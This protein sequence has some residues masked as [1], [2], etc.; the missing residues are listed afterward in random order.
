MGALMDIYMF[1][2]RSRQLEAER[3]E[4]IHSP[5]VSTVSGCKCINEWGGTLLQGHYRM[6]SIQ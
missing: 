4:G 5:T 6:R 3:L 2:V 1:D